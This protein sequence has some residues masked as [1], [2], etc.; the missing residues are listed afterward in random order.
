MKIDNYSVTFTD[1]NEN[2]TPPSE[3]KNYA[4]RI[5]SESMGFRNL[6][7]K[8]DVTDKQIEILQKMYP[9][10]TVVKED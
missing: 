6:T 8:R 2:K 7:V 9:N 4:D 10:C 5:Q 3:Y 1:E